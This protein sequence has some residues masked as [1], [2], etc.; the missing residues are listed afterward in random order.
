MHAALSRDDWRLL[1]AIESTP[2]RV[3]HM[4][5]QYSDAQHPLHDAAVAGSKLRFFGEEIA[6][7]DAIEAS[8]R[9]MDRLVGEVR[10]KLRPGD[11]LLIGS[12]HGFESFRRQCHINNWLAEK[13]YL[14]LRDELT[15]SDSR[16]P[17]YIDWKKTK[18][19]AIGLGTI[20]I[21]MQG[22]EK[23]GIVPPGEVPA[24][25]EAITRDLLAS[26]DNGVRAV[27]SVERMS[28]R[29][30]GP[31][32]GEMADLMV[33]F[34]EGY[35]VS[36]STSSGDVR[37]EE[38]EDGSVGLAPTFSDNRLAWSGD[39]VSVSGELVHGI[40]FSSRKLK[41]LPEV[42]DLLRVAPTALQLLGVPIPASYDRPALEFER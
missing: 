12:D 10:A 35:R 34:E 28:T 40:L 32:A 37:L 23:D 11:T 31:F 5:Y 39:H 6:L 7:S 4:C 30:A 26:T 36:W 29:H 42:P 21:N 13:G 3:Q 1:V 19:Y 22:R 2:D 20:F 27:R 17:D 25:I 41:P 14:A 18:A 9:S 33:G 15:M 8:Y 24:L 38:R 16:F